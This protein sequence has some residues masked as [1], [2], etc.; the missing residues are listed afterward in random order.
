M[1]FIIVSRQQKIKQFTYSTDKHILHIQ[2]M[3]KFFIFI[4]IALRYNMLQL[5]NHVNQYHFHAETMKFCS[6][7]FDGRH[8]YNSIKK[9]R[10]ISCL[11]AI[12]AVSG[13]K[14]TQT[15]NKAPVQ[16][17]EHWKIRHCSLFPE[18]IRNFI[19]NTAVSI[20]HT[21]S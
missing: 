9:W 13:P 20:P 7:L 8:S 5:L 18:R 6:V 4:Y 1:V 19:R 11:A 12:T 17:A 2:K 16:N 10:Y 3:I 21:A 14:G 15:T